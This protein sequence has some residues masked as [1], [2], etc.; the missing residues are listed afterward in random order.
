MT[1]KRKSNNEN[2]KYTVEDI[3]IYK[4]S[5]IAI[6]MIKTM[7]K[8]ENRRELKQYKSDVAKAVGKEIGETPRDA[9]KTYILPQVFFPWEE[10]LEYGE[11]LGEVFN[12]I[13]DMFEQIY[14]DDDTEE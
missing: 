7:P 2:K 10:R 9:L 3:R 4:A 1:A 13:Q 6:E 12:S 5:S 14:Y 8:P 11:C